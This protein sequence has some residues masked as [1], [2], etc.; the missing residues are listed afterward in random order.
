MISGED[1]VT[2]GSANVFGDLGFDDPEGELVKADLALRI[3]QTIRRRGLTQQG[4][5]EIMGTT[6]PKVSEL[7]RGRTEDFSVDRL[8]RYLLRLGHTVRIGVSE[9]AAAGGGGRG[10][11]G[12]G[13]R[14]RCRT[15][16]HPPPH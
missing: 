2:A 4:A 1:D 15:L 9:D 10:G 16:P 12:W 11:G 13:V 14:W 5:A 7:V 8:L 6:Q 3:V